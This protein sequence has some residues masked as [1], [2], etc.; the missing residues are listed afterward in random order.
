MLE[1]YRLSAPHP[2]VASSLACSS[3]SIPKAIPALFNH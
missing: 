1:Q 2:W 3:E